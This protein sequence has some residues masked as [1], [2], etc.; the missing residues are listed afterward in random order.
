[1][2]QNGKKINLWI[3]YHENGNIYTK[4]NYKNGKRDG[5]WIELD[6]RGKE[7]PIT[8]I[9]KVN[10]IYVFTSGSGSYKNGILVNNNGDPINAFGSSSKK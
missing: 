3:T 2:D 8:S 5:N 9:T 7:Y 4:G 6:T 1:M 10:G